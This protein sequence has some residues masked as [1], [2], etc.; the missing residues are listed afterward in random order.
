MALI[1]CKSCGKEISEK[2]MECVYCKAKIREDV[3]EPIENKKTVNNNELLK[4]IQIGNIAV[5]II[6]GFIVIFVCYFI[7]DAIYHLL[8]KEIQ[9]EYVFLYFQYLILSR[10]D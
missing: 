5:F 7:R 8:K 4:L 2:A 6:T 10:N 1:K 3:N 9:L